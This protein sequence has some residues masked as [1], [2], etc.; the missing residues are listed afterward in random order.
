[1]QPDLLQFVS[2]TSN[3]VLDGSD[4]WIFLAEVKIEYWKYFNTFF[5]DG[6]VFTCSQTAYSTKNV[7]LLYGI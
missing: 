2:P 3:N 5:L 6:T 4:Y 1:M 7:V